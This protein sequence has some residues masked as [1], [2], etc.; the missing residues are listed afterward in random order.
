ANPAASAVTLPLKTASF[1]F[2]AKTTGTG[3]PPGTLTVSLT[4]A[5][6]VLTRAARSPESVSPSTFFSAAVP[7][8]LNEY[9]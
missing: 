6:V 8:A 7:L 4:A 3:S 2:S 9:D 1:S 5:P